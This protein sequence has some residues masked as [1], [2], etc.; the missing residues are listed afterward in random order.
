M[1]TFAGQ[2]EDMDIDESALRRELRDVETEL[3]ELRDGAANLR[4]QIGERWFEPMDSAERSA[5]ITAAEE[6]E[7]LAD[8][9]ETRRDGL[10]ERLERQGRPGLGD[11]L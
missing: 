1:R 5:L 9:L 7:A 10:A 3:I 6:Q 4:R 8:S 2:G 11:A